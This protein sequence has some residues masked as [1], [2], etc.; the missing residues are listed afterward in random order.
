MAGDKDDTKGLACRGVDFIMV[1]TSRS[2]RICSY[3]AT[4][5]I[6]HGRGILMAMST[7]Q[8]LY[9]MHFVWDENKAPY[10]MDEGRKMLLPMCIELAPRKS[11]Y[12]NVG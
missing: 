6:K 8:E 4:I 9:V 11:P 3:K 12:M 1:S 5:N 2:P 10:I 7:K